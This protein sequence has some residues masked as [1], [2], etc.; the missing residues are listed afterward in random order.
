MEKQPSS[1]MCFVCG[2]DNPIGFHLQFFQDGNGCVY[3]DYT[4]KEEHQGFP[5]VMHGGLVSVLLDE[6][7]GR[8][9]IASN[10]WCMTAE[11]DVRFRKP[12][13]IGEPLRLKG[14]ITRRKGRLLEGKSELRLADGTLAAV[15]HGTYLRI[16]DGQL[17][18]Y[19][20]ALEWWQVD[21]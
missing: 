1:K 11:L 8:T 18:S 20:S 2:R 15:A 16:P 10:L 14:Q 5:G 17:Q 19:Q 13:P 7:L 6:T 4:P 9:A 12:V 3:A 21:E